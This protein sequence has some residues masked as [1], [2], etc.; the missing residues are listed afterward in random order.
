MKQKKASDWPASPTTAA[1]V[2]VEIFIGRE[3]GGFS[4]D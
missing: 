1:I 4:L 2:K 3:G